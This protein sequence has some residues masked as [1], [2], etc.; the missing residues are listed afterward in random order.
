MMHKSMQEE[1]ELRIMRSQVEP[2]FGF[3]EI[4]DVSF[5]LKL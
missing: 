3:C 1:R 2:L 5:E 4:S